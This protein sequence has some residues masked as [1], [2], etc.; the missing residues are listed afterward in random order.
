M[1]S[2]ALLS[3]APSPRTVGLAALGLRLG[4]GTVFLAHGLTKLLVYTPAGTAQFFSSH[5]FPAWTAVPVM[6]LEIVGGGLL[7]AGLFSRAVAFL[8]LPVLAGAFLVHLPNG[9]KFEAQGGGWE[10]IA[11]LMVGLVVQV[12]LGDGGLSTTRLLKSKN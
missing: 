8:L 1:T 7:I 5:G 10:F 3:S 12:L 6:L 11:V 9:W 2:P 4:L